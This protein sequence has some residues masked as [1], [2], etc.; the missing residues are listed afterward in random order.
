MWAVNKWVPTKKRNIEYAVLF[1]EDGTKIPH[2]LWLNFKFKW[3]MT[4]IFKTSVK[5]NKTLFY[6]IIR[7]PVN[8]IFPLV[9]S[10]CSN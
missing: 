10:E 4:K 1:T 2:N 3:Y 9:A 8:I 7:L 6:P 5:I